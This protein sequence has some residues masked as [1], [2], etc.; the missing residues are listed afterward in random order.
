MSP[1]QW[2]LLLIGAAGAIAVYVMSRRKAPQRR[3]R[4]RVPAVTPSTL[5]PGVAAAN[6]PN[7]DQLDMFSRLG[8]FDEF[9]VGKPRKRI[10]PGMEN[11]ID[12]P[13]EDAVAAPGAVEDKLVVLLIAEREGTAIFGPKIHAALRDHGLVYGDKKIYH[14]MQGKRPVYSVASLVK[15]GTLDPAEQRGF[16]TPGLSLF[17]LLPGPEAPSKAVANMLAT[18]RSLA[19]QLNADVYDS[20]RAPLTPATEQALTADIAA[21]AQKHK[22]Q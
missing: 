1:M 6:A 7:K 10:V 2:A 8:E 20:N 19:L 14:A 16:S 21:W 13:V 22:L 4:R 11:A 3:V 18:A 5:P 15:P 17:M 12:P 9:G